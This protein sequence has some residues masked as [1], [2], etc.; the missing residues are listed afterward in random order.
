MRLRT[1]SIALLATLG[2]ACRPHREAPQPPYVPW[3]GEL[4]DVP[5]PPP[6]SVP[7]EAD[8]PELEPTLDDLSPFGGPIESGGPE[9][10]ATDAGATDEG[11]TDD[12]AAE[13]P[14][15]DPEVAESEFPGVPATDPPGSDAAPVELP[16]ASPE[17]AELR[18]DAAAIA[19][20]AE[21]GDAA[22]RVRHLLIGFAG[23]G[24]GAT[25]TREEAESLAAE[26]WQWCE[27]GATLEDLL[28]DD[29][30]EVGSDTYTVRAPGAVVSG[31]VSRDALVPG[32]GDVA[33]RLDVGQIGVCPHDP[34][35]S[36]YGWHLIQRLPLD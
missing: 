7:A 9:V 6:R 23:S 33:W 31:A 26:L 3:Y 30:L 8:E 20:R 5:P 19:A 29:S 1:L 10:G 15:S 32:F 34:Q 24:A 28:S 27:D 25:R 12:A 16:P 17:V 22:I 21:A 13:P 14:S 11:S 36:P 18:A 35:S 4:D 2:T